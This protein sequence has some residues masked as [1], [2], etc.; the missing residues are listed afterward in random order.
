MEP[1]ADERRAWQD[2]IDRA[3]A[4]T[5]VDPAQVNVDEVL[6]L[7]STVARNVARPMV[8]VTAFIA[9]LAVGNAASAQPVIARLTEEATRH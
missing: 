3:C 8:P 9:G 4:A 5:G 7:A 6:A 1:T 2:W